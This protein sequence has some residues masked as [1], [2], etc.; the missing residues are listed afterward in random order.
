MEFETGTKDPLICPPKSTIH[1]ATL[2]AMES[3]KEKLERKLEA[4]R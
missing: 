1:E 4:I 3:E 2:C